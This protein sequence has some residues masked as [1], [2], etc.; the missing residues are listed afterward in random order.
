M[1]DDLGVIH[2]TAAL[3]QQ[4]EQPLREQKLESCGD[5]VSNELSNFPPPDA[6]SSGVLWSA[7]VLDHL[8]RGLPL[9]HHLFHIG[10]H[11]SHCAHP[12][13]KVSDLL[14]SG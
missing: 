10:L 6:R 7:A 3:L 1:S 14:P 2:E 4:T 11:S 8:L 13:E 9:G 12:A 5:L